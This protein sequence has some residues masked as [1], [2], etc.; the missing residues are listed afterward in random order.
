MAVTVT[1]V[2]EFTGAVGPV[3]VPPDVGEEL[4]VI[5]YVDTMALKLAVRFL[6]PLAVKV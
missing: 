6:F 3:V 2:P 1:L 5:V 4:V